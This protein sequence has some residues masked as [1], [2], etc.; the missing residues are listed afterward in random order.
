[1]ALTRRDFLSLGLGGTAGALAAYGTESL[2][3]ARFK[4]RPVPTI[5]VAVYPAYRSQIP[6]SKE[7]IRTLEEFTAI[8]EPVWGVHAK[9]VPLDHPIQAPGL[10]NFIFAEDDIACQGALAY[11]DFDP[12][13]A[14]NPYALVEVPESLA[15]GGVDQVM[16]AMTH[17]LVEMLVNPGCGYWADATPLSDADTDSATALQAAKLLA[18]ES[19]DPVEDTWFKLRG[20]KVTNF[21]YPAYFEPWTDGPL[22]YLGA[23]SSAHQILEGGYQLVRSTTSVTQVVNVGFGP[24][25]RLPHQQA[26]CGNGKGLCHRARRILAKYDRA[27]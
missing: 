19:A 8:I 12:T 17:E 25:Q 14:V 5:G 13:K 23:V 3:A 24:F 20:H 16:I 2:L 11:H 18:L 7:L 22:D 10:W 26:P 1:M 21:V 6:S 4:R 9:F 15:D 27:A